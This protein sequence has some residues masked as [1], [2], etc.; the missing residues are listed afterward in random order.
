MLYLWKIVVL[1]QDL[2]YGPSEWCEVVMCAS[3]FLSKKDFEFEIRIFPKVRQ[4][5]T[6]LGSASAKIKFLCHIHTCCVPS[7]FRQYE[8]TN[9]AHD[10]TV[11]NWC[12]DFPKSPIRKTK[13]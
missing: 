6:T 9:D 8:F 4:S 1:D 10:Y 13:Y 12:T 11:Y 5:L 7:V 3:W 2:G